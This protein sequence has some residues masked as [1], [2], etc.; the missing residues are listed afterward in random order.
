MSFK[1]S[2]QLKMRIG[3]PTE[4]NQVNLV[5]PP[6]ATDHRQ[7]QNKIIISGIDLWEGLNQSP[8]T[9]LYHANSPQASGYYFTFNQAFLFLFFF[10]STKPNS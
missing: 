1:V 5:H 10:L 3:C 6:R 4:L 7:V 8:D 9:V 2:L